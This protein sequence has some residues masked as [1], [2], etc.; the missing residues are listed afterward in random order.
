M[1]VRW[2]GIQELGNSTWEIHLYE[3]YEITWWNLVYRILKMTSDDDEESSQ[4]SKQLFFSE[5][6]GDNNSYLSCA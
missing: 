1:G 6:V 3:G 2:G 4:R 5:G